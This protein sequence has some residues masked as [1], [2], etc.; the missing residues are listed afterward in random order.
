[1]KNLTIASTQ[2][3]GATGQSETFDTTPVFAD[4]EHAGDTWELSTFTGRVTVDSDETNT[5]GDLSRV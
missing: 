4:N 2:R 1:M 3:S 5:V